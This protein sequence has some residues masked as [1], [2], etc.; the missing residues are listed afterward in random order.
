M[1]TVPS[2]WSF[3]LQDE[4]KK[5]YFHELQQ[6]LT[7]Q[8]NETTIYPA[9]ENVFKALELTPFNESNGHEKFAL[10]GLMKTY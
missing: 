3:V 1:L 4:L 6:F 10:R 8:Y 5:P 2:G 9:K 7:K